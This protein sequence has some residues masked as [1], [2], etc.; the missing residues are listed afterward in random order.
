MPKRRKAKRPGQPVLA[1]NR[2]MAPNDRIE[3]QFYKDHV[4][5]IEWDGSD[6]LK[7]R[8]LH[9][10]LTVKPLYSNQITVY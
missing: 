1:P 6:E 4:L 9:G 8:S 2:V 7:I 5:I 10:E 3:V